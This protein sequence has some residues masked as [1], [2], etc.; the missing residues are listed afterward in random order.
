MKVDF[1]NLTPEPNQAIVEC[2]RIFAAHGR[3]I[4]LQRERAIAERGDLEA[5]QRGPMPK[6]VK[7]NA[8]PPDENTR[9]MGGSEGTVWVQR[10]DGEAYIVAARNDSE[11]Q[12]AERIIA[13]LIEVGVDPYGLPLNQKGISALFGEKATSDCIWLSPTSM[14]APKGAP[15]DLLPTHAGV[16]VE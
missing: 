4:R 5:G 7:V 1:H 13:E 15:S 12:I 6:H 10:A 3:A 2:L 11:I 9:Y 14:P 8:I 16:F